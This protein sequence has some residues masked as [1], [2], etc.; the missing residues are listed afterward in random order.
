VRLTTPRNEASGDPRVRLQELKWSWGEKKE[1][2]KK[3][4]FPQV[5]EAPK[6]VAL[7]SQPQR[8][9]LACRHS[10]FFHLQVSAIF[11]NRGALFCLSSSSPAIC[12]FRPSSPAVSVD[13][14]G[15]ADFFFSLFL[16]RLGCFSALLRRQLLYFIFA[17]FLSPFLLFFDLVLS[18]YSCPSSLSP[19]FIS[20]IFSN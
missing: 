16:R 8:E 6:K 17:G 5:F 20:F 10:L 18:C 15:M 3:L 4:N 19:L 12:K 1:N 7:D 9:T 13:V 2:P 11:S 14:S